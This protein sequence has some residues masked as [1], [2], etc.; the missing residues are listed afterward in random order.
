MVIIDTKQLEE[1]GVLP[2]GSN[3]VVM[4]PLDSDSCIPA[5]REIRKL[6]NKISLYDVSHSGKISNLVIPVNDHINRSGVNPLLGRQQ[7]LMVDFIDISS[8]YVQKETGI[9]TIC[10]GGHKIP[11]NTEYPSMYLS[12]LAILA[13]V[14]GFSEIHGYIVQ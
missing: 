4:D 3:T 5:L 6:V 12:S 7:D 1:K 10:C 8:L 2:V 11:E 14:L 13:H 9:T